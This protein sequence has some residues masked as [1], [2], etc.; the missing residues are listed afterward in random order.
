M[1]QSRKKHTQDEIDA[2]VVAEA[3][4]TDKWSD[5]IHVKPTKAVVLHLDS[6]TIERAKRIARTKRLKNY[7]VW[8]ERII[9]KEVDQAQ[10][11][12]VSM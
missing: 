6:K 3:D 8:F 9:K 10:K 4:D 11:K 12:R 5:P 1:K 7:E 2:I